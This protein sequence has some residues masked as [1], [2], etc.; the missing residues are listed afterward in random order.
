MKTL[1][2]KPRRAAVTVRTLDPPR[3]TAAAALLLASALSLPFALLAV[4]Q[5]LL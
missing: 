5:A 4:I 2:Q 3:P 1:I